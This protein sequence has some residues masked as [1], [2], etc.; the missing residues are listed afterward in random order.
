M[1]PCVIDGNDACVDRPWT[2]TVQHEGQG[3]TETLSAT[4]LTS[5]ALLLRCGVRVDVLHA[6]VKPS[7]SLSDK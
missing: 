1:A 2:S 3:V 6:G 7:A 4:A 5:C